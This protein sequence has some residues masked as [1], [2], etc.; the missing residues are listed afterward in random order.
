VC[1]VHRICPLPDMPLRSV[2][3]S[4]TRLRHTRRYA[5]TC[6]DPFAAYT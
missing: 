2:Y 3:A 4:G 5:P 1:P 6:L